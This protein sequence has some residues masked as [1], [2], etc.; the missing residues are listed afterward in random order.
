MVNVL[1]ITHFTF[2][3]LV[4]TLA[5]VCVSF[6]ANLV[7]TMIYNPIKIYL[8]LAMVDIS[9]R[10]HL[11]PCVPFQTLVMT[12]IF[13]KTYISLVMAYVPFETRLALVTINIF[14]RMHLSHNNT[15]DV[16]SKA[17]TK[18]QI[19]PCR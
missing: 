11:V 6:K 13:I 9:I 7:L 3:V 1:F 5:M 8:A 2:H 12:Y 17:Q 14:V 16:F 10:M 15:F 18:V 4:G 19:M